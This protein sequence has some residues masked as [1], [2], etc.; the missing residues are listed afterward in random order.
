[1]D[2]L[3]GAKILAELVLENY[4]LGQN[5]W[6]TETPPPPP[7]IKDG[8]MARFCP[9]R[10][11][12]LDLAGG[13]AVPFFFVQDCRLLLVDFYCMQILLLLLLFHRNVVALFA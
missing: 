9:S 7:K 6:K 2:S 11:F 13:F 10:G 1:M 12:M 3:Y 4:N 5:K 8:K